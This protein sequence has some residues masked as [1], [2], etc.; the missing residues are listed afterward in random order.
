MD[1]IPP[2]ELEKI[3]AIMEEIVP[4]INEN[5][6]PPIARIAKKFQADKAQIEQLVVLFGPTASDISSPDSWHFFSHQ[7]S[8]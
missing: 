7:S 6:K 8:N 3:N 1:D 4:Y 2:E 5:K